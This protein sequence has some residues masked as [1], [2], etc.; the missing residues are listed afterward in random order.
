MPSNWCDPFYSSKYMDVCDVEEVKDDIL[1]H[2]WRGSAVKH[3]PMTVIKRLQRYRLNL[4]RCAII[5]KF[6]HSSKTSVTI[7]KC[8]NLSLEVERGCNNCTLD[9]LG[10]LSISVKIFGIFRES[11]FHSTLYISIYTI[12]NYFIL[13]L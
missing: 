2:Y 10:V 4:V 6:C 13:K 9:I 8:N 7:S 5:L 11:C 12:Y 1:K 3:V